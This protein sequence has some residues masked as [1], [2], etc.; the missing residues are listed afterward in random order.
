MRKRILIIII[1]IVVLFLF[2]NLFSIIINNSYV[3]YRVYS[4]NKWSD[5]KKNGKVA[6]DFNSKITNIEIKMNK[7]SA[8]LMS[9]Y[10]NDDWSNEIN[11]RSSIKGISVTNVYDFNKKYSLCYRTY[12]KK[13]KWLNWTCSDNMNNIS[14][15]KKEDIL[16][17]QFKIIPKNVILGDYLEN[18]N[19]NKLGSSLNFE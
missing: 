4:D 13:N 12:N 2:T 19:E 6:G 10:K 7:D 15:N 14:G 1:S 11:N 16:A 8:P 3:K 17:I 5:W 18:Y 9:F